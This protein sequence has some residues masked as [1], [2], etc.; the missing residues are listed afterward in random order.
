MTLQE[1]S[2]DVGRQ[3]VFEQDLPADV[4]L[5]GLVRK[6]IGQRLPT[7]RTRLGVENPVDG[8]DDRLFRST[9]LSGTSSGGDPC[10]A[11][12][13]P[14]SYAREKPDEDFMN[15]HQGGSGVVW[16]VEVWKTDGLSITVKRQ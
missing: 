9:R 16:V 4:A 15:A 5:L 1:D 7:L 3:L 8:H 11:T 13:F 10:H 14:N 6:S 12:L 2:A